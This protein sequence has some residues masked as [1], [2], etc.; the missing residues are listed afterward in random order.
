MESFL[1]Q[2]VENNQ[3]IPVVA[4]GGGLTFVTVGAIVSSIR[5]MVVGRAKEQTKRELAAYVAEGTISAEKA[6]E[7]LNAGKK[8]TDGKGGCCA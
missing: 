2:L 7:I 6:V 4:I 3:I 5:A 8:S 1:N